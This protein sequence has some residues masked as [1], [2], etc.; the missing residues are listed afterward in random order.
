MIKLIN[1]KKDNKVPFN[2]LISGDFFQFF[3]GEDL[4]MK[5]DNKSAIC[6]VSSPNDKS[7]E[8]CYYKYPFSDTN[9]F[10]IEVTEIK[11]NNAIIKI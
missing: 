8:Q 1:T 7:N 5:L 3:D 10:L 11:Y 2:F 9:V 4:W 6:I